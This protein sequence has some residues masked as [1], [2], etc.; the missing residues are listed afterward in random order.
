[1]NDD[2]RGPQFRD[3]ITE[4]VDPDTPMGARYQWAVTALT[5][6]ND[7]AAD[8]LARIAIALPSEVEQFRLTTWDGE[9][10]VL[11]IGLCFAEV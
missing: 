11:L 1:M 9:I 8:V 2:E 4:R 3:T 5:G 6:D 10:P 7:A